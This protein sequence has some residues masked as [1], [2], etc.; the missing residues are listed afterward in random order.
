MAAEPKHFERL[1]SELSQLSEDE[2]ALLLAE[3][4]RRAKTLPKRR[5]FTRPTLSGG[6]AWIG[7]ELRREDLYGDDGR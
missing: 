2:R 5:E 4:A 1:V 6:D 7:G 3:A